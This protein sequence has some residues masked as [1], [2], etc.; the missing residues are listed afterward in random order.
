M[1]KICSYHNGNTEVPHIFISFYKLTT[2]FNDFLKMLKTDN[3]DCLS[4]RKQG[5]SFMLHFKN[6]NVVTYKFWGREQKQL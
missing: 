5:K 1:Y 6:N 3:M 2:W 4:F